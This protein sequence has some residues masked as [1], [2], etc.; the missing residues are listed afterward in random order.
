MQDSEIIHLLG[1]KDNHKLKRVL[2]AVVV[3]GPC[4][5]WLGLPHTRTAS[6]MLIA[7]RK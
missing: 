7:V 5:A 1:M 4:S 6:T 3:I 2:T